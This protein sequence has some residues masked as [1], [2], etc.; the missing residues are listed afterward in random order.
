M[1]ESKTKTIEE[2]LEELKKDE[3]SSKENHQTF[4]SKKNL[5]KRYRRNDKN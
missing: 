2:R 1:N 5:N 4:N 3:K